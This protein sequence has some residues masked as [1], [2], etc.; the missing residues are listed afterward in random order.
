MPTLELEEDPDDDEEEHLRELEL[1]DFDRALG[2]VGVEMEGGAFGKGNQRENARGS[3]EYD[4]TL[5][6]A[7]ASG[8]ELEREAAALELAMAQAQE[9]EEESVEEAEA[10]R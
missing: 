4:S 3:D 8:V 5:M 1:G 9:L 7:G 6:F 10:V 2:K